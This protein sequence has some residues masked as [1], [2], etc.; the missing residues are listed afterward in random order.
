MEL[1]ALLQFP[2]TNEVIEEIDRKYKIGRN[3]YD[4]IYDLKAIQILFGSEIIAEV[5]DEYCWSK[6]TDSVITEGKK[7]NGVTKYGLSRIID[8]QRER[9]KESVVLPELKAI[10]GISINGERIKIKSP[11]GYER[12]KKVKVEQDQSGMMRFQWSYNETVNEERK[13]KRIKRLKTKKDVPKSVTVR[14]SAMDPETVELLNEEYQQEKEELKK[15]VVGKYSI[16]DYIASLV[17]NHARE[18]EGIYYD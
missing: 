15:C 6:I 14:L 7:R 8:K 18:L 12:T 3:K 11:D 13:D 17:Y 10:D 16:S 1:K 9:F 4:T 2:V 5:A